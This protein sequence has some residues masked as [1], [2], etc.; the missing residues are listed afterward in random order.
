[1]TLP[2]ILSRGFRSPPASDAACSLAGFRTV[3]CPLRL[4]V[5]DAL[6]CYREDDSDWM[7]AWCVR[8]YCMASRHATLISHLDREPAPE[9]LEQSPRRSAGQALRPA[10]DVTRTSYTSSRGILDLSEDL[11]R[12]CWQRT[13]MARG[14]VI[15]AQEVSGFVTDSSLA[16]NVHVITQHRFAVLLGEET[17]RARLRV[18]ADPGPLLARVFFVGHR[19]YGGHWQVPQGARPVVLRLHGR[20]RP[21]EQRVRQPAV[22]LCRVVAAPPRPVH[23]AWRSHPDQ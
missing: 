11:T 7:D 20:Q 12:A 23:G 6:A 5:D 16:E 17:L 4:R 14:H 19:G 21:H 10:I 8:H 22:R 2:V 15:C 1:M 3:D 13:S 18:H 9:F